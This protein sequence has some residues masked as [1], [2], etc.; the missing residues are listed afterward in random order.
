MKLNSNILKLIAIIAMSIDHIT[1]LIYPGLNHTWYVILLHIIGRITAPIMWYFI[2]EGY[3]YT[4]D[5]KKYMLRLFI[6]AIIS[7]FAYCFAF[8]IPFI[9]SSIF[10]STGILWSF[11]W[12]VILLYIDDTRSISDF[13][14]NL[15]TIFIFLIT[16]PSDW[17]CISV[18]AIY[19][20]NKYRGNFKYQMISISICTLMYSIVYF[21]FIDKIYGLLQLF[22]FLSF[23][24]LSLYNGTRGKLKLKWLFYYYYPLHLIIIGI[25]RIFLYGN[26]PLLFN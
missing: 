19:F 11:F 24:L 17:S 6:F 7:H 26:I 14:R 20:I 2:A 8:G 4:K 13:K 23:P 16:F 5:V 10:N 12:T 22:T 18:L 1:W 21:I 3:H 15:L 25:L 9:P